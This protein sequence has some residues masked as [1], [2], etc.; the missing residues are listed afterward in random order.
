MFLW[1][2]FIAIEG[3]I[4]VLEEMHFSAYVTPLPRREGG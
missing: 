3:V 4:E 2:D 1:V